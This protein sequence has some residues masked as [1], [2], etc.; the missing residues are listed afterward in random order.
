MNVFC[1]PQHHSNYF[2]IFREYS[3]PEGTLKLRLLTSNTQN[4]TFYTNTIVEVLGE[5][6][7]S[8]VQETQTNLTHLT[9]RG[10]VEQLQSANTPAYKEK[11]LNR[12]KNHY[13][14]TVKVWLINPVDRAGDVISRNLEIRMLE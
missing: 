12:F 6:F 3:L 14:P 11:L 5:V 2:S 7:I 10:V 1:F 9:S 13:T 4:S 8:N